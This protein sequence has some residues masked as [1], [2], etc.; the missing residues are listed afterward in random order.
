[1]AATFPSRLK[2]LFLAKSQRSLPAPQETA[3]LARTNHFHGYDHS[4][5]DEEHDFEPT[6]VMKLV[7]DTLFYEMLE[8]ATFGDDDT[9]HNDEEFQAVQRGY[10]RDQWRFFADQPHKQKLMARALLEWIEADT[11]TAVLKQQFYNLYHHK[12]EVRRMTL[13]ELFYL[14]TFGINSDLHSKLMDAEKR[15]AH[16]LRELWPTYRAFL[17]DEQPPFATTDNCS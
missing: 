2:Q 11:H 16:H 13:T 6:G 5:S 15:E 7:W 1:M 3:E 8:L 4:S 17:L 10:V 14:R 9:H 12:E